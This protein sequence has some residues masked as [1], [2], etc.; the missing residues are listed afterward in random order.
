MQ[1]SLFSTDLKIKINALGAELCSVKNNNGVEFIWQSEKDVWPRHAPVLF[2]IVGKLKDNSFSFNNNKF[3]LPQHGFAR[4]MEF[5]LVSSEPGTCTFRLA[6]N[7]ETKKKYPFDFVFDINYILN[8]STLTTNYSVKNN[9]GDKIYF[10]V[11]AHPGFNC[12]LMSNEKF[13]DYILEFE[14]GVY[15]Q[16]LLEGGLLSEDT[17][18]IELSHNQLPLSLSLFDRDALVLENNQV[19]K[20]SL[21]HRSGFS[22]ITMHC[23]GWPYF[24]IWSKKGCNRFV[25]LEPW[26]GV[27][28]SNKAEGDISKKKGIL[29]LEAGKEFKA[30]FS[31]TF[32]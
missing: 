24:G 29:S 17:K 3:E 27:A 10:S 5:E 6:S 8:G 15:K 22:Q 13:E 31:L 11:G 16:T 4:D 1:I 18:N 21:K 19:N 25:C 28:D 12:P 20:I 9:S 7:D 30:S 32:C 26:Y 2:P 23:E 14:E